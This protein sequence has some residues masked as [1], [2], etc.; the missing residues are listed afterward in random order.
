MPS[1]PPSEGQ[2]MTAPSQAQPAG[3]ASSGSSAP[4]LNPFISLSEATLCLSFFLPWIQFLGAGLS[5]LDIQRNFSSYRLVW[6]M[7]V[8][9]VVVLVL[10]L[11][12]Q[13][14]GFIRRLA[15]F[16]PFVILIYAMIR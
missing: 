4:M 1:S 13:N 9:A 14:T 10:S 7:P 5:G 3:P 8:L 15:G 12:R 16:C 2:P 6:L 11:A